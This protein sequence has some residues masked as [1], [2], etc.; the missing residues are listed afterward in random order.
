MAK[1]LAPSI[2][3]VDEIDALLSERTNNEHEASR[4]IK[5]EFLIHWSDLTRAAAGK[6]VG[7]GDPSRVLVLAATN[8]PWAIDEA[9]RRRFVRR[10]YIPLPEP[11]TRRKQFDTLLQH[12]KH[13]LN[14]EDM[15]RLLELTDG[16]S[17]SDITA[18]TKDAAMGPL[19][20]LGDKLLS[21]S[22]DDI[23]PLELKD[24]ERSLIAIRA[25]VSKEGL[26]RFEDWAEKYGERV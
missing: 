1:E 9:A 11:E 18:L 5:T 14:A 2:I 19:R 23:R 4:K 25:S 3:F 12:Q 22:V 7:T 15:A 13:C 8:L 6:Q 24:F 16:F 17:G 26:K 10:Q 20:E 21:M